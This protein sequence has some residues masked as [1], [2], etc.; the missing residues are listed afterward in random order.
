MLYKAQDLFAC[1]VHAIDGD[2][3]RVRDLFLD[4][5][6]WILRYLVIDTGHWLERQ[7]VLLAPHVLS[8]GDP[9]N[10]ILSTDLTRHQVKESPPVTA[11]MPLSRLYEEELHA[12]YGW[13]PYWDLPLFPTPGVYTYP[14]LG[15]L[16]PS[17]ASPPGIPS[18]VEQEMASERRAHQSSDPNLRSFK[19][20]K[21]YHIEAI[22]GRIG[23]LTDALIDPETWR[24]THLVIDTRNWL[25]GKHVVV[26]TMAVLG[27][28]W[29]GSIVGVNLSREDIR[30]SPEYTPGMLIGRAY[31]SALSSYDQEI[32]QRVSRET[33]AEGLHS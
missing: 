1:S 26:D 8:G 5:Q 2:V 10:G 6:L 22:D 17:A 3:G 7:E 18:A 16:G 31:K 11:D 12:Y 15:V 30:L 24:I 4:D 19:D 23:H 32:A 25:P 28:D 9:Q 13:M 21:G 29:E 27:M 20:A 33:G 14:P